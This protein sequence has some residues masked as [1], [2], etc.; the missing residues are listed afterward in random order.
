MFGRDRRRLSCRCLLIRFLLILSSAFIIP[1]SFKS[2]ILKAFAAAVLIALSMAGGSFIVRA[3][4]ASPDVVY[5][6]Y[7]SIRVGKGDSLWSIVDRHADEYFESKQDFLQEV[8]QINHLLDSDI[9]QGDYLIIP[10]YSSE[11]RR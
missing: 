9:R 3:E 4:N 7:T 5:K 11:F 1:S 6:Y 2:H 8:I 10:Y